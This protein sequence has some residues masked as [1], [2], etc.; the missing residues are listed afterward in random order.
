MKTQ[1]ATSFVSSLV[2]LMGDPMHTSVASTN[3]PLRSH[4]EVTTVRVIPFE[5]SG[6]Q[7]SASPTTRPIH[8]SWDAF[9]SS[10]PKPV[11]TRKAK[12]VAKQRPLPE[13]DWEY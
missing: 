11:V 1:A 4:I 2:A 12:M 13:V 10:I 7:E 5:R 9:Q 8:Q 3:S 6:R